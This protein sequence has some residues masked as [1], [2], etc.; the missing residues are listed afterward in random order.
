METIQFFENQNATS[1]STMNDAC[2]GVSYAVKN[3]K[4][5]AQVDE[6]AIFFIT[7]QQFGCIKCEQSYSVNTFMEKN[8]TS[9]FLYIQIGPKM[10][11]LKMM[12]QFM[13]QEAVN[14]YNPGSEFFDLPMVIADY[15]I[16]PRQ[17]NESIQNT[18]LVKV[19]NLL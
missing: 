5:D 6:L 12:N 16:Q 14:Q 1:L 11:M 18:G 13:L 9:G 8:S 10:E 17:I 15:A 4:N 2:T 7:N 19:I 3:E